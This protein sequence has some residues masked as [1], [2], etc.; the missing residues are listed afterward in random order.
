MTRAETFIKQLQE[1]FPNNTF[2][3]SPDRKLMVNGREV[4]D[5]HLDEMD[6]EDYHVKTRWGYDIQEILNIIVVI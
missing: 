5:F 2:T 3:F 6:K 4:L 1:E